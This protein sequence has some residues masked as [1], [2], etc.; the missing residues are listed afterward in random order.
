MSWRIAPPPRLGSRFRAS[1]MLSFWV[2][3]LVFPTTLL[4]IN[5]L[6]RWNAGMPQS[7]PGDLILLLGI[8]DATVILRAEH[9]IDFCSL[10]SKPN[11]LRAWF[12]V[13]GAINAALWA[14]AVF[15]IERGLH[16]RSGWF[17]RS[18]VRSSVGYLAITLV[19]I[20]MNTAPFT[21]GAPS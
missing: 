18:V 5:A 7:A 14:V 20:V 19:A 6:A 2:E 17:G 16:E 3:S 13:V 11:D 21:M 1:L 9:L 12:L 15:K 10:L 8:F 4:V